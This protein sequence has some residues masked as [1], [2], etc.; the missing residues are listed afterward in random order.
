MIRLSKLL[1]GCLLF[2]GPLAVTC[3]F[4]ATKASE[5]NASVSPGDAISREVIDHLRGGRIQDA[6]NLFDPAKLPGNAETLFQQARVILDVGEPAS[7]HLVNRSWFNSFTEDRVNDNLVY[8]VQG[9]TRAALVAASAQTKGKRI[10]LT[11]LNWEPAPLDLRDRSPFTLSGKSWLHYAFLL[12]VVAVPIFIVCTVVACLRSKI[13]WKWLWVPFIIVGIGQVGVVWLDGPAGSARF[14]FRLSSLLLGVS[15][16][17]SPLYDPWVIS[18]S[19]PLGA[20]L[21]YWARGRSSGGDA[22][23]KELL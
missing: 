17:K 14:V 18:V 11:G 8:H 22:V 6:L 21:F 12:M 16:I 1:I 13:R 19:L 3:I 4:W 20:I 23:D 9:Q 5:N 15:V 7:V 2:A 10:L